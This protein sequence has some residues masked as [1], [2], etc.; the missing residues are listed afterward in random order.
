MSTTIPVMKGKMGSIEYYLTTMKAAEATTRIKVAEQLPEWSGLT[1]E[2]RVQ[3]KLDWDRVKKEIAR[4]L[5][6]DP[7]RFYGALLVAVYN[8]AGMEFE[9]LEDLRIP[10]M[11]ARAAKVFGFLHL[12]GD[13]LWFALDGQH[14]LKGTDVAIT[15]LD[16]KGQVIE[17]F[18][19]NLDVAS[20][21]I[22]V[23][24]IPF[25]PAKRA[26][27]VFN[28]VNKYAKQTGKGDN[29]I[30]SED[31]AFAIVTRWIMGS[32]GHA[33]VMPEKMVNW[34]SNTLTPRTPKFTTI[35]VLYDGAKALIERIHGKVDTQFCPSDDD[36]DQYYQDVKEMWEVL[37]NDFVIYNKA[38]SGLPAGLSELRD[39]YLCMKPAGQSALIEA[40]SIARKH[41]L[42]YA[43]IAN[44]LN[45]LPWDINDHLWHGVMMQGKKIQAGR[46][47]VALTGRLIAHMIGVPY[48]NEEQQ[49]LLRDYQKAKGDDPDRPRIE[50]ILPDP[51]AVL[52]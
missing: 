35:S 5:A 30:T 40:V 8:S 33:A 34:T 49:T 22:A 25:E 38:M 9:P 41:N 39:Q 13:E 28:K 6:T 27:K 7:D 36:L 48:S 31:D 44:G 23:M 46:T 26:R 10:K 14:R 42:G 43:D 24:L 1:I 51:V 12:E 29:I 37:L 2:E 50:K 17:G 15:G 32:D 21:E 47:P 18:D 45:Q 20:D 16:E 3:R 4:F 52:V 11:Y 19:K